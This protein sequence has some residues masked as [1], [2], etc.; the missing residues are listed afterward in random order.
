MFETIQKYIEK[1]ALYTPS[2]AKLWDNDH[3]SKGMLEAHMN[4]ILDSA[5]RNFSFVKQSV[6]WIAKM[7]PPY[8]YRALLDLGC[9]PGIYA[10]L[11]D[12]AGYQIT[13]ID[14]SPR[15]I[16]YARSSAEAANKQIEYNTVNYLKM[17]YVEEF[18][19]IT[20][21]YCDFGVLSTEKRAILLRKIYAALKT[22]GKFIFDVFTPYQY[23]NQNEYK[24]W[25]YSQYGFWSAEPYLCLNSFYRYDVENTFLRQHLVIS[26]EEVNCY[27]IWDHTFIK[28][29]IK[30]DLSNAGFRT[31]AIY[32]DVTGSGY[33]LDNKQMCVLAERI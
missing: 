16:K 23:E 31:H 26:G 24:Q 14:L 30:Q 10:E 25:E 21:I 11:F 3:I 2:T 27:N 7:A 4:P 13:G 8:R 12:E 5:T 9:G 33:F 15:S 6:Q 20:L 19:V 1:P 17:E 22:G 32:G 28:D 18:D 29:E